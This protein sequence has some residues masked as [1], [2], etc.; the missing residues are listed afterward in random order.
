MVMMTIYAPGAIQRWAADSLLQLCTYL[1][2][3]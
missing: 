1:T 3:E 2:V